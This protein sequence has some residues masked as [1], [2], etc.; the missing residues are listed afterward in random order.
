MQAKAAVMAQCTKCRD[1]GRAVDH[2]IF[3]CVGN[4]QCR[5]LH[6]MHIVAN[7]IQTRLDRGRRYLG[8]VTFD[9]HQLRTSGV[10]TRR[11]AFI[12]LNMGFTVANDALMRL[13]QRGKREAVGTCPRCHPKHRD[14][15]A[16]HSGECGIEPRAPLVPI[17]CGVDMVGIGHGLHDSGV[18]RGGIVREET[19]E[20]PHGG[21]TRLP[22]SA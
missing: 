9:Q 20:H 13:N 10:E 6:L 15:A 21:K 11:A 5:R 4:R 19:H 8:A 22:S 14:I 3:G 7:A 17:I 16:E 2:A 12:N 18:H 1:F